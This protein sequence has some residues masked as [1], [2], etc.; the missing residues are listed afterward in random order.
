M[1]ATGEQ[2]LAVID[3]GCLPLEIITRSISLLYATMSFE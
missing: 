2:F 3:L 1:R